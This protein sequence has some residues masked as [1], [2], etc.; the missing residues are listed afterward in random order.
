MVH[1]S[2]SEGVDDSQIYLVELLREPELE[3]FGCR[4]ELVGRPDEKGQCGNLRLIFLR[5]ERYLKIYFEKA[6]F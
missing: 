4:A 1:C 5:F 6:D 2:V 3:E